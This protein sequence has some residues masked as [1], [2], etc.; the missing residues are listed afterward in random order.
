MTRQTTC[1]CER[2][3]SFPVFGE[4][5]TRRHFMKLAGTSVLASFFADVASARLL[6]DATSLNP[7]LRNS[8]RNCILIFLAGAPSQID[9]FDLKEGKWTPQD[10]TPATFG[11]IRFPQGLMPK[12]AE[13]LD[14]VAIIRSGLSWV[15]VHQL[16]QSWTQIAR[17]PTGATGHIAPHIGAVVSL[18]SQKT[19][20]STDILPG[21]VSLGAPPMVKSGYLPASCAPF[22]VQ[23]APGGLALLA[24]PKGAARLADRWKLLHTI[25]HDRA[26]G[27][28]GKNAADMDAFYT[29]AK[30]LVDSPEANTIFG[31]TAEEHA[32]YGASAF[33]DACVVAR[34]LVA[35]HRGTRF[36]Q[37]TFGGWDHHTNI[38]SK[39]AES[40]LYTQMA[41]FD[42]GFG[43]MLSD[44]S[45]MPGAAAGRTMLDETMVVVLGEFGR[46]VGPPVNTGRDHLTRMS[47]ALAGG[48]VRGGTII[49]K[50]DPTGATAA[51]FG[52]RANRDVRPEDL[53][54]TIYSALGIDY[55]T[56]RH[57]DP[58]GRGFE[59]VPAAKDG[60]Y[61]PV[62][63]L[64]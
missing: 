19:R 34:N 23:P 21:F 29:Q 11:P 4:G 30:Q 10:F 53:T 62:D 27:G 44:L 12:T 59:Y 55:T 28:L 60:V 61:M 36:V 9:T 35:A 13:Q 14:K 63:E 41:Q 32:R 48:G 8:A 49:G 37:I 58:L 33:G 16:G 52:W 31:F 54:T 46:T 56:V 40:S 64:F 42:P 39:K 50:T 6:A 22:D 18:E 26:S 43:A 2:H 51:E 20:L 38:Y 25:D 15:A 3:G 17:N 57:D 1:E 7:T 24:H 5:F 45:I 47:I